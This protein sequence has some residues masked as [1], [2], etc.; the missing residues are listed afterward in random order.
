MRTLRPAGTY[1]GAS[2]P[3][4][5]TTTATVQAYQHAATALLRP[6]CRHLLLCMA[7]PRSATG[8]FSQIRRSNPANQLILVRAMS[9]EGGSLEPGVDPAAPLPL[10]DPDD[11]ALSSPSERAEEAAG[12]EGAG[13]DSEDLEEAGGIALRS[14]VNERHVTPHTLSPRSYSAAVRNE[15]A[16]Y[17]V[18]FTD[19]E[20]LQ[21]ALEA[22][23]SPSLTRGESVEFYTGNPSVVQYK[24][25]VGAKSVRT[26]LC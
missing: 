13:S 24:G 6:R 2:D 25:Q 20:T 5:S 4:H 26:R 21:D 9:A 8:R 22:P 19:I 11:S 3:A 14:S 10:P 23:L 16:T 17:S 1:V 7:L 15:P 18:A 12:K